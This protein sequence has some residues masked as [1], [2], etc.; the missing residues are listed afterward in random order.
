MTSPAAPA[1]RA[2]VPVVAAGTLVTLMTF[3]APLATIGSISKSLETGAGGQAW[4]LSS[5]SVGLAALLLSAGAVAD[6]V[7]RRRTFVIGLAVIAVASLVCVAAPDTLTFVLARVAQGVGGAAVT[8]AGLGTIAHAIPVG[9]ARAAATGVW[10]ASVG[11]GIAIGPLLSAVSDRWAS[12]RD[13][14]VLLAVASALLAWLAHRYVE[15]SRSPTPR[16]I[17]VWGSVLLGSS[18]SCLLAALVESRT[19]EVG[20][21]V[22]ALAAVGLALLVLFVVVELRSA[23]P[24]IDLGLL[25]VPRFRAATIGAVAT[26][27]GPIALFSYLIGFAGAALDDSVLASALL[28]LGW[29]GTSVVFALLARRLPPTWSGSA[30]LGW[31]LV[32]VAVGLVSLT[33]LTTDA[34]WWRLLPGLLLAGIAT[35]VLNAALGREAVASVPPG[36]GSMGS[37][38]NNTARYLGAAIGVTIVAVVVAGG[39]STPQDLVSGWNVAAVVTAGFCALGALTIAVTGRTP[40]NQPV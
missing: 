2:V 32:A 10:G 11:A 6:D 1:E 23:A 26:G 34:A 20:P 27:L 28:L 17:D 35:G 40:A 13:V 7:G 4:I 21:Q 37:G 25:R 29:S 15:E 24:M 14:Y 18:L 39:A 30:Q 36:R 3:T 5:M 16:G 22:W 33:G 12:W 38:A 31:S 9:P 19:G 8:A